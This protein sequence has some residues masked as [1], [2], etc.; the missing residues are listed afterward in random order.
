MIRCG[1][2][3]EPK[4]FALIVVKSF[5]MLID[6]VVVPCDVVVVGVSVLLRSCCASSSSTSSM[7]SFSSWAKM[8]LWSMFMESTRSLFILRAKNF[9]LKIDDF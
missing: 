6:D 4:S 1:K 3:A 5:A 7:I 9:V 2:L 8:R